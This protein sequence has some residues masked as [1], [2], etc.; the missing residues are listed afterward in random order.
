[1]LHKI[2]RALSHRNHYPTINKLG[3]EVESQRG[4]QMWLE[5]VVGSWL[6]LLLALPSFPPLLKTQPSQTLEKP[7]CGFAAKACV[8]G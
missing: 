1:M 4:H 3:P 2:T 7:L 6:Y 8:S 5:F